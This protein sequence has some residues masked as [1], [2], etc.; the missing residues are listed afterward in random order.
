MATTQ[1]V[2]TT[3]N[4]V[5]QPTPDTSTDTPITPQTAAERAQAVVDAFT[6]LPGAMYSDGQGVMVTDVAMVS[7]DLGA[8]VQVQVEGRSVEDPF[9]V[10]NPPTYVPDP[11]GDVVIGGQTFRYDPLA[12]VTDAINRFGGAT[13]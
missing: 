13:N 9:F 12:A 2:E 5:D 3:G 7:T 11:N 4:V 6:A 10:V 8:A 1:Q